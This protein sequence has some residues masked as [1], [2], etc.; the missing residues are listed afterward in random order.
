MTSAA[1][2]RVS[3]LVY[4]V[5]TE[6][7]LLDSPSV[8][9]SSYRFPRL[10]PAPSTPAREGAKATEFFRHVIKASQVYGKHADRIPTTSFVHAPKKLF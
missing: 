1:R 4:Y 8:T 3:S 9:A 7:R 10:F 6:H 2:N 5:F